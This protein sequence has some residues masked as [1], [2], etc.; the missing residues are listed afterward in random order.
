MSEK[1]PAVYRGSD[2]PLHMDRPSVPRPKAECVDL[3]KHPDKAPACFRGEIG[4]DHVL[5]PKPEPST[6]AVLHLETKQ[7]RP[8]DVGAEIATTTGSP[9]MARPPLPTA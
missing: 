8:V 7:K 3:V 2:T 6:D 9:A 4:R 1:E 5:V